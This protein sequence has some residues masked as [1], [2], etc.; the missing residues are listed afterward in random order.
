MN[1]KIIRPHLGWHEIYVCSDAQNI[2]LKNPVF[3]LPFDN[4]EIIV[5]TY[6]T[7]VCNLE[8]FL[9]SSFTYVNFRGSLALEAHISHL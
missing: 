7:E 9:S 5:K 2:F 6:C 4:M 1:K 8:S 3:D